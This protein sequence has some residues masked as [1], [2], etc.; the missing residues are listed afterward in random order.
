MFVETRDRNVSSVG[1][2]WLRK[3]KMPRLRS[4]RRVPGGSYKHVAPPEL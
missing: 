4:L 3:F 2:A 1:A